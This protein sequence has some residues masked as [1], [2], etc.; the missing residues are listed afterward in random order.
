LIADTAQKKDFRLGYRPSLDGLRGI[1]VLS[2]LTLHAYVPNPLTIIGAKERFFGIGGFLG[3]D[4]FFVLSGFLITAL[5]LQEWERNGKISFS[6]FYARRALRLLPALFVFLL[7]CVTYTVGFRARQ[8][9]VGALR[10][11]VIIVFYVSNWVPINIYPLRHLWSLAVEEQF[12]LLWPILLV[13]LMLLVNKLK[14]RRS[15]I[16]IFLL[17]L[18]AVVAINRALM[19]AQFGY[20]VRV[21]QGLDTRAD[22]LLVGCLIAF[23]AS[24]TILPKKLWFLRLVKAMATAVTVLLLYMGLRAKIT[25]GYLYNGGFT[26][27][28]LSVG[29]II[30]SLLVSPIK[31]FTLILEWSVLVW[32]G[33]LSYG[34]YVWHK[35]AYVI[36]D[37]MMPLLPRRSETMHDIVLP[38][39]IKIGVSLLIASI[40]FYLIEQP[41]LRLKRRFAVLP[42]NDVASGQ[43]KH[44]GPMASEPAAQQAGSVSEAVFEAAG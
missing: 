25:D 42:A 33:R 38:L 21:Y 28:A 36:L 30:T 29:L 9:S 44:Q 7:V 11:I 24:W 35:L 32:I 8:E 31:L 4:I 34:I 15:W 23:L 5:L 40:S 13:A 19:F 6:K 27:V 18:I 2:V 17:G 43:S 14:L 41:L 1:A 37:P 12:Y 39:A 20:T 22:S 3:V 10:D 16:V 26:V